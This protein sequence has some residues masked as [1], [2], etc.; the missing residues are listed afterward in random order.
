[1]A[2]YDEQ[3]I[4][5]TTSTA[6]SQVRE[7][8]VPFHPKWY[9]AALGYGL[10]IAAI[11]GGP[12]GLAIGA[13]FGLVAK[14]RENAWMDRETKM[15]GATRDRLSDQDKIFDR[16]IE[17]ATQ[18]GNTEKV[19]ELQGLRDAR[20]GHYRDYMAG[21]DGAYQGLVE[22]TNKLN[23][24][25]ASDTALRAQH[26]ENARTMTQTF[27]QAGATDAKQRFNQFRDVAN[28]ATEAHNKLMGMLNDPKT[29]VNAPQTRALLADYL[30]VGVGGMMRDSQSVLANAAQGV[31]G[32]GYKATDII[33]A[34][35]NLINTIIDRKKDW[36]REDM[37]RIALNQQKAVKDA[38]LE[39]MQTLK[40]Q[41]DG[42]T[43][44]GHKAQVLQ[45]DV[46]VWDFTTGGADDLPLA[47]IPQ[48][49][50]TEQVIDA[51]SK[52]NLPDF[53]PSTTRS[54]L[55]YKGALRERYLRMQQ[56]R[57]Q[58]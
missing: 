4:E 41:S 7:R 1:M 26:E 18:A 33:G 16:E 28:M 12:I 17:Q 10:P 3:P 27:V 6:S 45:A 46:N 58:N 20:D 2:E 44:L 40:Q 36:T 9:Q 49:P 57:P 39:N 32:L 25:L 51:T 54:P 55:S 37:Y 42:L 43:M 13:G 47:E 15:A 53:A 50:T 38:Y 23:G 24:M 29:D 30:S 48:A 56:R 19:E 21:N 8:P 52:D 11:A 22:S 34:G 14:M 35:A 5:T 31:S